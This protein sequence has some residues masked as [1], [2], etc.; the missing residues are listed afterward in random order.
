MSSSD[1][2]IPLA[3]YFSSIA[4]AGQ[5][6]W[7][8]PQSMHSSGLTT[9]FPSPSEIA[10]TGHS[11]AHVPQHKHASVINLGIIVPPNHKMVLFYH[12]V[13]YLQNRNRFTDLENKLMVAGREDVGKG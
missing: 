10:F 11:P 12:K 7:Q 8:A 2:I 3:L 1:I 4:S 5:A 9:Y 13:T 6:D